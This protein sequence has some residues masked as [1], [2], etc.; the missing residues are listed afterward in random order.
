MPTIEIV[1]ELGC[2]SPAPVSIPLGGTKLPDGPLQL[3][4]DSG[5]PIPAQRDGER[6]VAIFAKLPAGKPQRYRLDAGGTGTGVSLKDEGPNR[7]S[8]V[9]PEGPFSTYNYSPEVPRPYFYPVMGPGGKRVTRNFPMQDVPEEREAKDQDHPHHR[10]FWTAY[11]EVNGVDNWSE[12]AGKHGW[13]K[14]KAFVGRVEGAVFGGFTADAVWTSHDGQPVL[15]ERRSIRLYN[16]G[17]DRRLLDYEVQLGATYADVHYGD[18]KEGGIMSWRVFHTIKGKEGG[19]MENSN[20]AVGEKDCWGK[21]AA[22][23]DYSGPVDGAVVGIAM[24]DHPSNLNHPCFWHSRDYGLV[25]LN[26]FAG[27]K[28][29]GDGPEGGSS[30]KKGT[31]LRFRYRVLIHKGAPRDANV[32]DAFHAWVQGATGRVVG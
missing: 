9:L 20:G 29:F 6:L 2:V 17:A 12:A 22:W 32:E 13:T 21:R 16:V 23:L 7:L 24:M 27:K 14:H 26:P 1:S 15:D 19:R 28:A 8:L 30:Q 25:G 3:R 31:T 4:P 5:P 10:S 11:D 18:T